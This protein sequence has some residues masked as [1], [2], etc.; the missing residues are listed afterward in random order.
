[1]SGPAS[2]YFIVPGV[3]GIYRSDGDIAQSIRFST[4]QNGYKELQ[5][6]PGERIA[7]ESAYFGIDVAQFIFAGVAVLALLV[8]GIWSIATMRRIKR[9]EE[10][11]RDFRELEAEGFEEEEGTDAFSE[12][13]RLEAEESLARQG[14]ALKEGL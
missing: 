11:I 13:A 10:A 9:I 7:M 14:R 4:H 1:M 3:G 2:S 6:N 5:P 8:F 12:G